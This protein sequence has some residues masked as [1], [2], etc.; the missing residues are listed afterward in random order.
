MRFWE[1]DLVADAV[2]R[3]LEV[4]GE[5]ARYV[6]EELRARFQEVSWR[7]VVGFRNVVVHKYFA[8]DLEIVWTIVSEHLPHLK[9]VVQ[10]MLD[11]LE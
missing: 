2:V 3:N 6:P 11:T 8:V 10:R 4:I 5:A 1:N 9:R 7:R